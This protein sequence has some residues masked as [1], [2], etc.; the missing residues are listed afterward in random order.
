MS[1]R[2]RNLYDNDEFFRRV[3][4]RYFLNYTAQGPSISD[5]ELAFLPADWSIR[6]QSVSWASI[7]P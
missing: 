6:E 3:F 1:E 5:A 7:L 4:A 2:R